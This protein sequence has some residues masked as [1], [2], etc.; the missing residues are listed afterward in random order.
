M[1][2]VLANGLL[3]NELV[4]EFMC[5]WVQFVLSGT[6]TALGTAG[7]KHAYSV[8][9]IYRYTKFRSM[10]NSNHP[11]FISKAPF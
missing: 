4:S 2:I 8:M 7:C 11:L 9:F 10:L 3:L 1:Q 5:A 6:E